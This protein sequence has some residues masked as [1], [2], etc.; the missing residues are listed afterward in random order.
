MTDHK[1]Y[2]DVLFFLYSVEALS[3]FKEAIYKDPLLVMSNWNVPNLSPCDWN[4]IKC[5][6]SKDHVIKM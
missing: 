6:P 3:R 4:G 1:K 5:S 2:F